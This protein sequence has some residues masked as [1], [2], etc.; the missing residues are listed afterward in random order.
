MA[1][2]SLQAF[3]L[4]ASL[5]DRAQTQQRLMEQ[6]QL[7]AADQVMRQRQYDLQNQIQSKALSD[8]LEESEAQANEFKAF[9]QLGKDV[10]DYLTNPKP[11]A[12]FPVVPA[13]KSRQFRTEADR[14]LNNLEK[15]SARAALLKAQSR[16]EAE[17]D[18]IAASTLNEAIRF[19][20]ITKNPDGSL[21]INVD[22][23][24]QRAFDFKKSEQAKT[25]AQTSS[26]L[27][28][29]EVAKN[30][31]Q[32][33]ISEGAS[34]SEIDRARLEVQK[35][36]ND[37]RLQLDREELDVKRLSGEEE[38]KL[39]GRELDI[40]EKT[41]AE[42]QQLK[43]RKLD[44]YDQIQR[45]RLAQGQARIDQ[46]KER[47]DIYRQKVLQ[48]TK[49]SE[50][51]LNA[52]DD[53][54]VKKYADD[55]ANKQTIADAIGY[56]I[57]ILQDPGIEDYVKLN[58]ANAIAKVLNSAE[59]RD[60]VGVEES[61]RLLG[62]LDLFNLKRAFQGGNLIGP[63]LES[64]AE[65]LLLKQG[66]LETRAKES[67]S[68]VNDIY[69]RYGMNLPAGTTRGQTTP[70]G[71]TA[72]QPQVAPTNAPVSSVTQTTN[73]PTLTSGVTTTNAPAGLT[74]KSKRVRQGGKE[75]IWDETIN[76]W[77]EVTQ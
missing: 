27:G 58:S 1:D 15:Y 33:L 34:K 11:D 60:A 59:G 63:D 4:G 52:V 38:R 17:A 46:A 14:M 73:A 39:K 44:I 13:F 56:E 72:V 61:K 65:K 71:R 25:Q 3:Q 20:A 12:K 74:P 9:S 18:K 10:S 68:R 43:S 47:I 31:L 76:D 6:F 48:P 69:S 64:F 7:Q 29:L 23:L 24:N 30:N 41:A 66:E 32:R 45:I 28:N 8:A 40:K 42:E 75:Y 57:G 22:L 54:L 2:Q 62:E 5:F 67:S 37:A 49:A 36:F 21:G 16:A 19:G 35:S 50:I 53:R 70:V 51:K 55:I 77:K 26:L